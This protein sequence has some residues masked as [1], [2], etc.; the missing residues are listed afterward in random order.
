MTN[1]YIIFVFC[2]LIS[3]SAM[4]QPSAQ[5]ENEPLET[6]YQ[7]K[8]FELFSQLMEE[9]NIPANICFSPLSVQMAMSMVQ[10]G[11]AGNT[12]SQMQDALGTKGYSNDE[13]NAFNQK[14]VETVTYRPPYTYNP[15]EQ[16]LTEEQQRGNYEAAYPICEM[17]NGVWTRPGTTWHEQFLQT[18]LDSYK[19]GGGCV[20]FTTQEGIDEIN[21]WVNDKTHELIPKVFDEPLSEDLAMVLA[22]A[23]YFK[24]SWSIPFQSYLTKAGI[25][26]NSDGTDVETDMM[27]VIDKF[28]VGKTKKYLTLQLFYGERDFSMTIFLP[29]ESTT[30][31]DLTYDEWKQAFDNKGNTTY[32][33]LQMP[34]FVVEGNYN[35]N[36]VLIRMGMEH[37]FNPLLAD[38]SNMRDEPLFIGK[39]FQC[40]KIAVDEN[41]TE[42]AAVTVVEM[43]DN[44]APADPE[45]LTIDRPFYFTIE[46][47]YTGSV[48][49]VG[50]VNQ[51][52]GTASITPLVR[53]KQPEAIY[54]LQGRRITSTPQQGIYIR[55]G[56]KVVVK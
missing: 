8:A 21:G 51:L 23:L 35:L 44:M 31:P 7:K 29:I 45:K 2:A 43:Y 19:A 56:K 18:L 4:S 24:G 41:G 6:V 25:F 52:Q 53:E 47:R 22:N 12:L 36:G 34:S 32:T 39:V 33:D 13:V 38:F 3:V 40:S 20:D 55:N 16:W 27:R 10:N 17:A 30:L 42:A 9:E 28:H 50:R 5:N 15:K 26:H 49:F 46:N 1:K 37:A 11:A 54:D 48:L 14:L